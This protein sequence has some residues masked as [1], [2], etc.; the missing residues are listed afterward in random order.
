MPRESQSLFGLEVFPR[1]GLSVAVRN[2]FKQYTGLSRREDALNRGPGFG[3]KRRID[4]INRRRCEAAHTPSEIGELFRG[5]A[6]RSCWE[7]PC[8]GGRNAEN[9]TLESELVEGRARPALTR[10]APPA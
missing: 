4:K 5:A 1:P 2:A 10:G 9:Q 3:G 7:R 8:Y 6:S